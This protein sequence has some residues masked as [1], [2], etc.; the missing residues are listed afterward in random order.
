MSIARVG[1]MPPRE[2]GIFAE[3][4]P[5]G[6][7]PAQSLPSAATQKAVDPTSGAPCRLGIGAAGPVHYTVR[8][9]ET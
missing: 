7:R 9:K 2:S 1:D 5:L 6:K 3:K 4:G 8:H